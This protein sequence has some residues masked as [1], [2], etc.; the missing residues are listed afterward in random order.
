MGQIVVD[1]KIF[2]VD[3]FHFHAPA[4]HLFDGIR[5]ALELHIVH[6]FYGYATDQV[7]S[8]DSSNSSQKENLSS[9]GMTKVSSQ[10]MIPHGIH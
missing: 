7:S 4:E 8:E 2:K 9:L 5:E 3:Q 1:G 10:H 6:K